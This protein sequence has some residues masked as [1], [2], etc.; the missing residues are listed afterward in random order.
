MSLSN[1]RILRLKSVTQR[2]GL[3]KS[4]IYK[5]ASTGEFPKQRQLA[6]SRSS[7]WFSDEV[8]AWIDS[9]PTA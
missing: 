7:G 5:L 2:T 1:R 3:S 4:S 6:S 8:Q 9:R